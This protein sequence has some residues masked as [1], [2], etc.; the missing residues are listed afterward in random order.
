MVSSFVE[1]VMSG[2]TSSFVVPFVAT[3]GLELGFALRSL[4]PLWLFV[5]FVRLTTIVLFQ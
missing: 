4:A 1:S 2:V 5:L 3:A